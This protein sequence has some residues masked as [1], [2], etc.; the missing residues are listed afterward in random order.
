[1]DYFSLDVEGSEHGVLESIPWDKV[2]GGH[3]ILRI[4]F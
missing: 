1:V 4:V 3:F 2:T